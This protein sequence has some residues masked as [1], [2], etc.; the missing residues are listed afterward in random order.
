VSAATKKVLEAA[1][2]L[3]LD[4]QAIVANLL[5]K[6]IEDAGERPLSP[7]W[8]AEINRRIQ[9]LREGRVETIPAEKVFA[10]LD[11]RLRARRSA[12]K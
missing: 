10:D 3:D 7:A 6:N 8:E 2:R 9:A 4:G 12:K 11:R 1:L 5:F